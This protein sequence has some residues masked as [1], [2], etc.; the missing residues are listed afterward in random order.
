MDNKKERSGLGR[1]QSGGNQK[2]FLSSP[3]S[4]QLGS[5]GLE[6]ALS[7]EGTDPILRSCPF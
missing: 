4:N 1:N 5:V 3:I 7:E 6:A 2:E